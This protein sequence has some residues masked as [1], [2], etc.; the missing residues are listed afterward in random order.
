[1]TVTDQVTNIPFD[2]PLNGSNFLWVENMDA[3]VNL[4]DLHHRLGDR[5]GRRYFPEPHIHIEHTPAYAY[6]CQIY[7]LN[8]HQVASVMPRDRRK[9]FRLLRD[10]SSFVSLLL[11]K[12]QHPASASTYSQS[13]KGRKG[14][15]Y[16]T[17]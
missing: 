10:H 6:T 5:T 4:V 2:S 7:S 12:W 13:Q 8:I 3:E 14:A 17:L 11:P 16:Q 1:M 9:V 15:Y